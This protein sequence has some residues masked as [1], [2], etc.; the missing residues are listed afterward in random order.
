MKNKVFAGFAEAVAD[1]E[2]GAGVMMMC[3]I[4][5]GGI[6]QNLIL[7]LRD[8]GPK[9]LTVYPCANFGFVGGVRLLPGLKDYVT[10]AVLIENHQVRKTVVTWARGDAD[11]VNALERSRETGEVEVEFVP[12]GVYAQRLLAAGNG[13]AGFYSPV[14]VG[15]AYER[16]REK[17]EID[18]KEYIFERPMSADY[19][20]VRAHKADTLGNLIYKGTMRCFN[21]LIA[22]A[23]RV[24]IAEVDEIVEP[25]ALTPDEIVTPGVYIDRI[26]EIGEGERR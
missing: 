12:V 11:F 1:I 25:G 26:V 21:P 20:F 14:G 19:G 6:A 4:G 2:D 10:P 8:L 7:A 15:T 17:R 5:Q 13:M 3:L 22:K 16:G 18:G 9:N 23:A 24:T